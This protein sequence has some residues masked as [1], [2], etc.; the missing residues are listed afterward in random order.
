MA[1]K[2]TAT[3]SDPSGALLYLHG[4][5]FVAGSARSHRQITTMLALETN[6]PVY[7]L[8]YRL[9]PEHPFPAALDDCL[10]AYQALLET[11]GDARRIFLV[12]D[13][14][15]GNLLLSAL[16][17]LRNDG[18]TLPGA[19]VAIS[20]S[21]DLSCS[22]DSYETRKDQDFFLSRA[23]L[24]K[25]FA[26]YL[27]SASPMD[28]AASPLYQDLHGLPPLLLQVGS[29]EILL[30]DS[31]RFADKLRASGGEVE[32]EIWPDMI[33][34]WHFFPHWLPEARSAVQAIAKFIS[35]HSAA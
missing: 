6:L 19:A 12:G 28:P 32:L 25:D 27:G 2:V 9:A 22:S 18:M 13:S 7:A 23:G 26:T 24:E 14:A 31:R 3:A 33:H 8:E 4:G 20:P 30:D 35:R 1:E 10:A 29:D 34:V 17:Q 15:G 21:T 16:C 5:A 11:V